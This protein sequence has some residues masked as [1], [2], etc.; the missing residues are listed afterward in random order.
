LPE[1]DDAMLD[2]VDNDQQDIAANAPL[3]APPADDQLIS[4]ASRT[5]FDF[6]VAI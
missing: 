3:I 4:T 5:P 6:I 2:T 1:N